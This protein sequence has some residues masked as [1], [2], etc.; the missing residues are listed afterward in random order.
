MICARKHG[1][2]AS[3]I[4]EAHSFRKQGNSY[5][6]AVRKINDRKIRLNRGVNGSGATLTLKKQRKGGAGGPRNGAGI[7]GRKK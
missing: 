3:C 4:D 5:G 1:L 2:E 6:Y 7:L